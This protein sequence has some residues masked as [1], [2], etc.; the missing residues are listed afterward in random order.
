MRKRKLGKR[1]IGETGHW[2]KGKIGK[3][4]NEEK[5]NKDRHGNCCNTWAQGA[6]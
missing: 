6:Q 3:K 1:D 5:R 4:G 2:R